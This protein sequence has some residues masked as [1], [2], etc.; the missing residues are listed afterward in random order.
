MKVDVSL[1]EKAFRRFALFDLLIHRKMWRGPAVFALILSACG[2]VCFWQSQIRG[3][4]LLG[5]VLL[6][7]GLG[8]PCVYFGAFLHSVRKK[9]RALGLK[10]P[11]YV[12]SLELPAD[13]DEIRV[14]NQKEEAC[15]PW[16]GV[17]RAYRV[18]GAVY[19]Y[20]TAE[21]A[22]ILPDECLNGQ[23]PETLWNRITTRLPAEKCTRRDG[24]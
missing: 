3:A 2:A 6:A 8:V 14:K 15:Y 9:A 10:E 23:D 4:A 13:S 22:F 7:V 21:R 20:I 1:T 11:Q 19:L 17:C 5:G 24:K 16:A 18:A 12:Y